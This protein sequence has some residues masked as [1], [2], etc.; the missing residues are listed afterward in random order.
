[1]TI[2]IC[3]ALCRYVGFNYTNT[4]LPVTPEH[5]F[6]INYHVEAV[7]AQGHKH[8]TVNAAGCGFDAHS[9]E[10]NIKYFHIF[11]LVFKHSAVLACH[12]TQYLENSGEGVE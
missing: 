8:S 7:M 2:L 10:C 1:M 11:N 9:S 6:K 5:K 4:N 3:L 12:T